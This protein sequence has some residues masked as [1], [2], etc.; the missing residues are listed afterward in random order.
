MI[1]A[2]ASVVF[3]F[4]S[5]PQDAF[6][7]TIGRGGFI[8]DPIDE[9]R[10]IVNVLTSTDI[11]YSSNKWTTNGIRK[12]NNVVPLVTLIKDNFKHR[13]ALERTNNSYKDR[14]S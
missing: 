11:Y 2:T 12:A 1:Y 4:G 8:K 7:Y 3:Y 9:L 14:M 6:E 10:N 5:A 13:E